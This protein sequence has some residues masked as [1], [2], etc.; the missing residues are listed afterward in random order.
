MM[1]WVLLAALLCAAPQVRAADPNAVIGTWWTQDRDGVVQLYRCPAGLCGS[2]VGITTFHPDGSPPV[3]L[4]GRTRCHLQI[5]P[6][7]KIDSDGIWNSHIIDPDDG[8]VYTINLHVDDD[9]RLRM[10]GYIGL[11]LFG[12]TVFWT[13]FAGHL[14]PDCHVTP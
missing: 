13:R 6:D 3:D 12:R 1:R 2:V 8:K 5:V 7:G 11:P 14:T 4:H 9:G 10:R